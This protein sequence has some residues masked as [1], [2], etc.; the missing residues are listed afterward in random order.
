[1]RGRWGLGRIIHRTKRRI[2]IVG[3]ILRHPDSPWY[4]R[5]IAVAVVAYAASPIDIVPDFIPILGYLDDVILLPLGVLLILRLTPADVRRDAIRRAVRS[6]HAP[7]NRG[8]WIAAG[9]VAVVWV[10]VIVLVAR[11]ILR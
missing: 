7:K 4:I 2:V 9:V 5:L 1:M 6:S 8:R 10:A 3:E 11:R